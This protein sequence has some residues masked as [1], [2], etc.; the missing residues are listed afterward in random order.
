ML[1]VFSGARTN[2]PLRDL[3][4]SAPLKWEIAFFLIFF[5][6]DAEEKKRTHAEAPG[7]NTRKK[8]YFIAKNMFLVFGEI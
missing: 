6:P 1:Y 4:V 3:P 5:F 7:W 2:L 8:N